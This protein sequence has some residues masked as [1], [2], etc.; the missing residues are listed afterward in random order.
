MLRGR[1]MSNEPK[2]RKL[3]KALLA[4]EGESIRA[5]WEE[6][7]RKQCS[8]EVSREPILNGV[9]DSY[10]R[11]IVESLPES[12]TASDNL[13]TRSAGQSS[14]DVELERIDAPDAPAVEQVLCEFAILRQ[15]LVNE[16]HRLAPSECSAIEMVDRITEF[17]ALE[18]GVALLNAIQENQ[19]GRL[20]TRAHDIRNQLFVAS[21]NIYLLRL[22][23][24][25]DR[26]ILVERLRENIASIL[27]MLEEA[28]AS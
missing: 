20:G 25:R 3:A 14:V 8:D 10:I 19:A 24:L 17:T 28:F 18:T 1:K 7:A 16:L 6:R 4:A 2:E 21:G 27:R 12:T 9:V 5:R 13:E 11:G 23:E 15:M 22:S 26:P